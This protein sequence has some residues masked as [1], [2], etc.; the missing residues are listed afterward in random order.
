MDDAWWGPSIPLPGGP[1]F[2]LAERS[3][4]GCV[5]VNGAGERFVNEAAPYVDVVHAMYDTRKPSRPG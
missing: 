5:I 4:P 2:C 1:Y 3:L